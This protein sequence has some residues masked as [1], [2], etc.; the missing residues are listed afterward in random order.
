MELDVIP[1]IW[2]DLIMVI[3]DDSDFGKGCDACLS[4]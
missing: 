2:A 3:D 1:T 4:Q